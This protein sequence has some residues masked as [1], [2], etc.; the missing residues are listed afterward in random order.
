MTG[1]P[2]KKLAIKSA[3]A[4]NQITVEVLRHF[5]GRIVH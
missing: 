1:P 4:T 3:N 5:I 2:H